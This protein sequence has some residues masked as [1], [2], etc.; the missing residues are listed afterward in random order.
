MNV[1]V[2]AP[3][4]DDE[5]IG[6]GGSLCLHAAKGDHIAVV[7]LTSGELGLKHLPREEAWKVREN[8][9]RAAAKILNI[10]ELSFL[11]CRDWELN[12][13]LSQALDRLRPIIAREHPDII[14]LPHPQEWH[15]DH[16]ATAG[17]AQELKLNAN[18][19]GYEVWTP[20]QEHDEVID[21]SSVWDRK[22]SALRCHA[23]QLSTW[24]YERA[25]HG[26][27]QFRGAM[28]GRCEFAEV[29]KKLSLAC[30]PH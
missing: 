8:E 13:D 11:R 4:P 16:K 27:A 2:L 10:Q 3:H 1:L 6:C 21:I 12:D 26:L 9:A 29:F 17:I 20:L 28:A 19:R 30:P 15:P 5:T 22:M 7:F 23:S 25:M 18:L 14:Y 24:P